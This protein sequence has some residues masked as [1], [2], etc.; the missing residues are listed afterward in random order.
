MRGCDTNLASTSAGWLATLARMPRTRSAVLAER[1]E[2]ARDLG[3]RL[4]AAREQAGLSQA[5][6]A[7]A[8][9]IP[10][11]RVAKLELGMRQLGFLEGIRLAALYGVECRDVDPAGASGGSVR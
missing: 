8:L 11:S 5:A 3:R 1:A 9:G 6:A 7:K 2:G 4:A 10:Q